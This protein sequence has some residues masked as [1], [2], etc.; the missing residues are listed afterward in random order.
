MYAR[1]RTTHHQVTGLFIRGDEWAYGELGSGQEVVYLNQ[2][3]LVTRV[4]DAA[5]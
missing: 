3:A 2:V 5:V 1:D 4:R